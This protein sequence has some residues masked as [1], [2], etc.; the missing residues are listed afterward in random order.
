VKLY[1]Y[2]VGGSVTWGA[3]K[4]GGLVDLGGV[5]PDLRAFIQ[6]GPDALAQARQRVAGARPDCRLAEA[7]ILLPFRPG[8]VLCSGVNYHG[9]FAENPNARMPSEPF[10]FAKLPGAVIGP[11]QPIRKG[12]TEQMDYEVEFAVVIG[13]RLERYAPPEAVPAALFGYTVLHDVSARDVQFKENQITLGKNF[14]GFSP[15]GP[16][17]LTADALPHPERARLRSYVNGQLMQ[18][19]TNEDWV[20]PL[21]VLIASLCRVM[22]LEPGDLVSTGT[23]RGVGVFRTPPVFLQVGDRVAVEV[24]EIGRLENWVVA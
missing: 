15:I 22:A 17:V 21:P 23:P 5:A 3:E 2:R 10:F 4:D 20:F 7:E 19:S 14:D 1:T 8:K 16:C 18:D 6:A 12:H 9:H 24:E 11:H 13:R